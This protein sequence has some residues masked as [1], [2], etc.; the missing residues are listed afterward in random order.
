MPNYH[1]LHSILIVLSI[2]DLCNTQ[3]CIF[4]GIFSITN[5]RCH[6]IF[7]AIGDIPLEFRVRS[8]SRWCRKAVLL[9]YCRVTIHHPVAAEDK[10]VPVCCSAGPQCLVSGM[11]Y[12][13]PRLRFLPDCNQGFGQSCNL[14]W[15]PQ[16]SSKAIYVV[17]RIQFLTLMPNRLVT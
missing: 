14:I 17:G 1:W 9:F 6:F 8:S 15:V 10:S 13:G 12:L 3:M 16:C 7:I 2:W 11:G 4:T 5:S